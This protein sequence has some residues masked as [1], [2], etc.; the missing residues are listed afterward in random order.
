[1]KRLYSVGIL[2]I[3]LISSVGAEESLDFISYGDN[4]AVLPGPDIIG[5]FFQE[6]P[7]RTVETVHNSVSYNYI[8]YPVGSSND[9]MG[10]FYGICIP[11]FTLV[12]IT[13]SVPLDI[14]EP[15]TKD[16]L[17]FQVGFSNQDLGI[18]PGVLFGT[19]LG[20]YRVSDVLPPSETAQTD[21]AIDG[22]IFAKT[23]F[24]ELD[25]EVKNL[26]RFGLNNDTAHVPDVR[27]DFTS[28]LL[29]NLYY[30][31]GIST[32]ARFKD[33]DFIAAFGMKRFFFGNSLRTGISLDLC[34][35]K[36]NE[37]T[38]LPVIQ[39]GLSAYYFLPSI[40]NLIPDYNFKMLFTPIFVFLKGAAINFRGTMSINNMQ[41][42]EGVVSSLSV[43]I[44]KFF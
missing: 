14:A 23:G 29:L 26:M 40:E 4:R 31:L 22:G 18:F 43:G 38:L 27:V 36:D 44:S 30:N 41:G 35:D 17:G 6:N 16:V 20:V 9:G 28:E 15:D 34:T 3:I 39:Y 2:L 33:I 42:A 11:N 5:S 25:V 32:A 10:M 12:N 1:M 24:F 7:A 37:E 8:H 19:G 13:S 21:L